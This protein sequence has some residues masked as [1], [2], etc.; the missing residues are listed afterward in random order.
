MSPSQAK[1][2]GRRGNQIKLLRAIGMVLGSIEDATM[3]LE[4]YG[5][6]NS[7]VLV[8]WKKKIRRWKENRGKGIQKGIDAWGGGS[9]IEKNREMK[10]ERERKMT[11][12][13]WNIYI[14][15]N[16]KTWIYQTQFPWINSF[17]FF[18]I[19]VGKRSAK[20]TSD[21]RTFNAGELYEK[22]KWEKDLSSNRSTVCLV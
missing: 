8:V 20:E 10:R 3:L 5:N 17:F 7:A 22:R 12:I 9:E 6:A 16:Q 21:I 14:T 11:F 13:H 19:S 1:E 2:R 4:S 15:I 18:Q